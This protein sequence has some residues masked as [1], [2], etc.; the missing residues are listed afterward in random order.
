MRRQQPAL[1]DWRRTRPVFLRNGICPS[2][3]QWLKHEPSFREFASLDPVDLRTRTGARLPAKGTALRPYI[4]CHMLSSVDGKIDGAALDGVT[5]DGE[6]EATGAK[7][8]A[9]PGFAVARRCSSTS[10]RM[11]RSSLPRTRLQN[12]GPSLS[13]DEQNPM[14]SPLIRSASSGKSSVD[15]A[16]TVTDSESTS[17]SALY[18]LK[19]AAALTGRSSRLISS[20]R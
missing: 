7:L 13:L 6:Y 4:I 12:H 15:L 2:R 10:Q 16:N 18:F 1:L 5:G 17:E 14:P 9:M 11:S 20:M 8:K 3:A 19:E